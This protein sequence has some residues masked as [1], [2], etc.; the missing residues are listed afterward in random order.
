M[1][2]RV[3]RLS[4]MA[5]ANGAANMQW[6][7]LLQSQDKEMQEQFAHAVRLTGT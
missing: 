7:Q 4:T 3:Q 2:S 1:P 5:A 6:R